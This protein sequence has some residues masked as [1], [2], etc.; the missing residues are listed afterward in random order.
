MSTNL[1]EVNFEGKSISLIREGDGYIN[2][3]QLCKNAG[4]QMNHYLSNQATKDFL[5]ALSA[6]TGI[7]GTDLIQIKQGGD[8]KAQ[9]TW[10]HPQV[11]INLGQWLSPKF[12]VAVS[13]W[14]QDWMSG[15]YANPITK[16]P[17][18]LSRMDILRLAMQA[19]EENQKLKVELQEKEV[20]VLEL[21]NY[22]RIDKD[23]G[24]QE[25][26]RLLHLRPNLF[27]S[28]LK[29]QGILLNKPN[30]PPRAEH[31]NT[32]YFKI[33]YD[34]MMDGDKIVKEYQ[35]TMITPKGFEW[36]RKK[37]VNGEFDDIK[38]KADIISRA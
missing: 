37:L 16:Q 23:K 29:E 2:A 3:T 5:E 28:K 10:I 12:A 22:I 8:P 9:G 27:I 13:K 15:K 4:K 35:Q 36:L 33:I 25:C 20:K 30:N 1:I 32:G 18:E 11:A 26:A 38:N 14:V 6:D 17:T 19:E 24:L 21:S 31:A 34:R 7:P